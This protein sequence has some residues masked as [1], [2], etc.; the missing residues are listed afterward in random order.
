M[1]GGRLDLGG[2][3][4]SLDKFMFEVESAVVDNGTLTVAEG[5]TVTLGA[6]LSGTGSNVSLGDNAVLD[7]AD[8]TLSMNVSVAGDASIGGGTQN[9]AISVAAGKTLTLGG[10]LNG[11]GAVTLD[12]KSTLDFGGKILSKDIVVAG[13]PPS[14]TV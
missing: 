11:T 2:T 13:K 3:Q 6:N 8:K 12:N 5:T 7:L 10:N 14:R 9:G 4:A 1:A